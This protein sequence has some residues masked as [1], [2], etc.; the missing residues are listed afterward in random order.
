MSNDDHDPFLDNFGKTTNLEAQ[1]NTGSLT[2]H[3]IEAFQALV[4]DLLILVIIEIDHFGTMLQKDST[5]MLSYEERI[6]EIESSIQLR[7]ENDLTRSIDY[8][9][10]AEYYIDTVISNQMKEK[11]FTH[12]PMIAFSRSNGSG[13]IKRVFNKILSLNHRNISSLIFSEKK[14]SATN[15]ENA[16][17]R[18]PRSTTPPHI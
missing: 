1:I 16:T 18:S 17:S 15:N 6:E 10:L 8:R 12:Y 5:Q 9:F 3:I 11:D 2:N 13:E 4:Y 14:S 7:A